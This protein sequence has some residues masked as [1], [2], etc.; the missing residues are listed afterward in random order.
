MPTETEVATRGN[1]ERNGRIV[2]KP[3]QYNELGE[4]VEVK[5]PVTYQRTM[6]AYDTHRIHET[7]DLFESN[8]TYCQDSAKKI[9]EYW[10]K[11][12]KTL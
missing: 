12:S 11:S 6:T 10:E 5:E 9:R 1:A 3:E 4:I 8:C 2:I 7:K